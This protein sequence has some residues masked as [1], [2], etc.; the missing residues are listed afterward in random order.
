MTEND[1]LAARVYEHVRG[2][3]AGVGAGGVGVAVFSADADSGLAHRANRCGNADGRHA[4]RHI[5]PA[6]LG[7][8]RLELG[9]EFLRLGRRLV[10]F[11]VAGNDSLTVLSV[12]DETLLYISVQNRFKFPTNHKYAHG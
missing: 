2:D 12:H 7:H 5:A 6:T 4:Q 1:V 11:P 3:F 9:H 10:H 8:D